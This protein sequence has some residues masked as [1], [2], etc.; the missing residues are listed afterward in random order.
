MLSYLTLDH[1]ILHAITN[2]VLYFFSDPKVKEMYDSNVL[3]ILQA[4]IEKDGADL[5]Q[6][7]KHRRLS[8][9]LN[10]ELEVH[11]KAEDMM[12]RG[13]TISYKACLIHIAVMQQSPNA[14]SHIAA[15]IHAGAKVDSITS[16]GMTAFCLAAQ[17]GSIDAAKTLVSNG[18]NPNFFTAEHIN[19]LHIAVLNKKLNFVKFLLKE[20]HIKELKAM[21]GAVHISK[22]DINQKTTDDQKI[23]ALHFAVKNKD[24]E[25]VKYLL[26]AGAIDV[27]NEKIGSPLLVA[28]VMGLEEITKLL[29]GAGFDLEGLKIESKKSLAKFCNL[30]E[31]TINEQM[32]KLIKAAEALDASDMD[33]AKSME[34]L[35]NASEYEEYLVCRLMAQKFGVQI[36]EPSKTQDIVENWVSEKYGK[37]FEY[38]NYIFY[39]K[40]VQEHSKTFAKFCS[41]LHDSNIVFDPLHSGLRMPSHYPGADEEFQLVEPTGKTGYFDE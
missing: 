35:K 12:G 16:W 1:T 5:P 18:A 23:T 37:G 8:T 34:Y 24:I 39:S 17:M 7:L 3:S 28:V 4:T 41:D 20:V 19:P 15:L 38:Q 25:M 2:E 27:D 6:A 30:Q 9:D 21:S 33:F 32:Q 13:E 29:I 11:L 40:Y 10:A 36:L 22:I 26:S 14:A 31:I